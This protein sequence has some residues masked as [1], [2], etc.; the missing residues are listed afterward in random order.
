MVRIS[1]MIVSFE[2]LSLMELISVIKESLDDASLPAV[3]Q[4]LAILQVYAQCT[5]HS[6]VVVQNC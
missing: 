4:L 2:F 3:G 5:M 1:S 6:A